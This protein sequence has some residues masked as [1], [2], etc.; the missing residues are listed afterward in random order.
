MSKQT[1]EV[2]DDINVLAEDARALMA[3]TANVAEEQVVQARQRLA[4]ALKR[5]Q[6]V[7]D[8]VRD[9]AV[10]ELEAT[11]QTVHEHPY[12]VIGLAFGA[13]VVLGCLASRRGSR[14]GG[15]S[16]HGTDP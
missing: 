1:Q 10:A 6:K 5:G 8:R 2:R 15:P 16:R 11:N 13:G 12:P 9:E 4:A 7:Y 3:A 14:N